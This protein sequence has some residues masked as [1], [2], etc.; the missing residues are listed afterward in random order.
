VIENH[1]NNTMLR[2]LARRSAGGAPRALQG[3]RHVATLPPTLHA[4]RDKAER[5]LD[6]AA[7]GGSPLAQPATVHAWVVSARRQKTRT[8]L[9]LTDGTLAGGA[10]LQAVAQS[11]NTRDITPGMALR[12][13]GT[14]RAGRGTRRSQ[15]VEMHVDDVDVLADCNLA[16]YPLA[17]VMQRD[18]HAQSTATDI[19]RRESHWKART[20]HFAA[21]ARTRARVEHAMSRWFMVRIRRGN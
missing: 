20:P 2:W 8:F 14:M 6:A 21:V 19:V 10:T 15:R 4:T 18:A 5:V 17:N 11:D 1:V 16:T 3:Y 9:E 13:H 7:A 12:V